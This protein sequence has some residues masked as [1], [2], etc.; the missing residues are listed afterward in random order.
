MNSLHPLPV[1]TAVAPAVEAVVRQVEAEL[2]FYRGG[3]RTRLGRQRVPYPFHVTRPFHLDV[4]R[5]DLATVYLQSASG[6]LYRDDRLSLVLH[7]GEGTATH[8]TTQAATIVH[9]T[10]GRQTALATHIEIERGG[11]LAYTPDPLVLFP[12]AHIDSTTELILHEG[13]SAVLTDAF[14]WH[15]LDGNGR[16]F[17]ACALRTIVLDGE[18]RERMR[19]RGSVKGGDFLGIASPAGPYRAAGTL[20]I[21]G[22]GSGRLDAA[23]F[24]QTLNA[25]NCLAGISPAPNGIGVS[26]RILAPAGGV[27][28][29]GL[30]AGFA[31]AFEAITGIVPAPRRK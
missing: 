5:P 31:L 23:R 18:G 2:V 9:D 29:R 13:A 26:A 21:L 4:A 6:G 7:G 25:L 24:D 20:L 8:V 10:R 12:G 3:G 11:F 14:A 16:P 30:A 22:E 17:A 15:N 27:L 19:D 1:A 28:A